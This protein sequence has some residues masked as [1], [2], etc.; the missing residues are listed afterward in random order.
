MAWDEYQHYNENGRKLKFFKI[1]PEKLQ[2]L[3]ELKEQQKS[4]IE[5]ARMWGLHHSSIRAQWRKRLGLG[6]TKPRVCVIITEVQITKKNTCLV[7]D[8]GPFNQG[9]MYKEYLQQ[10]EDRK[11][12]QLLEKGIKK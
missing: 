10:I 2:E 7:P 4:N 9:Y 11:W 1:Y 5:I 3:Y 12:K 6:K 8:E